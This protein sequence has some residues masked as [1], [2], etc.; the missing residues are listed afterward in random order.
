MKN[1]YTQAIYRRVFTVSALVFALTVQCFAFGTPPEA[2]KTSVKNVKALA[3]TSDVVVREWNEIAFTTIP[4]QPPFPAN[5][6]MAMVQLAVFEAVNAVTGKYAPYFGTINAPAG[7]SPEAAAVIAAHDV[8]V[9]LVPGQA[10]PLGVR[11]DASLA[12]IADGQSKTDGIAV[13][14]AAAAAVLADRANDGSASAAFWMPTNSDPYEWQTY[15]GCPAG[16]GAFFHWQSMKPFAIEN[17]SQFRSAPPPPL[18]S[19][20]YARDLNE[21]QAMGDVNST[22]RSQDR[23]DVAR[24]YAIYNPPSL[25]NRTLLQIAEGRNDEIT[26]TART[27]AVMNM[28]VSDAAVS[29]FETKYFYRIWRPVTAIPRADEDGNKRT[30]PGSFTPLINTPCFPSYP[31]AHGSLSSAAMNVLARAYGRFG[32]SITIEHPSVPGFVLNYSD[33][34]GMISDISDARVFGGIH[35]RF[36]QNA[37]EKQGQLIAGYV[38]NNSLLKLEE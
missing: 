7:A 21:V 16:G 8:L 29:V 1:T 13:G 4:P 24:L 37:G 22:L 32:H 10:G 38:H 19:A 26:D 36:D 28:A 18:V 20:I 15:T 25:W 31:S 11:R 3:G 2:P 30:N 35:F 6:D 23:T 12:S 27:M 33:I 14:A 34:R 5:R 9:S 17:S